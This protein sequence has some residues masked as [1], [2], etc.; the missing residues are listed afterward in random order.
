MSSAWTKVSGNNVVARQRAG[1]GLILTADEALVSRGFFII[2][3]A[4]IGNGNQ[5]LFHCRNGVD[6]E[7][8][9]R[10]VS[11]DELVEVWFE[12]TRIRAN[13]SKGWVHLLRK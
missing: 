12:N 3:T 9:S 10:F 1:E 8:V 4:A 7:S 5:W 2:M 6:L 13:P 11:C